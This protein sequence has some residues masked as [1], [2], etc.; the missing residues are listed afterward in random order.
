MC[1]EERGGYMNYY[2]KED[3]L[4]VFVPKQCE[5][6]TIQDFVLSELFDQKPILN[7][8]FDYDMYHIYKKDVEE[9]IQKAIRERSNGEEILVLE[10][11]DLERDGEDIA[12]KVLNREELKHEY[13]LR[14]F[15]AK[16][17]QN[18]ISEAI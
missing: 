1:C 16:H 2:N 5:R 9:Y 3:L 8:Q 18:F 7:S 12:Y 13:H 14:I 4:R 6:L 11:M 17:I 10:E 15:A